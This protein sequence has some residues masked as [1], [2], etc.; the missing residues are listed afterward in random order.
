MSPDVDGGTVVGGENELGVGPAVAG[1]RFG[2]GVPPIGPLLVPGAKAI[3][4][5]VDGLVLGG[6][7]LT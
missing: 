5:F 6:A 4:A 7:V 2:P 1:E 3:G